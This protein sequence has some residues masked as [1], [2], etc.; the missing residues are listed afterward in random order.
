MKPSVFPAFQVP[1][2]WLQYECNSELMEIMETSYDSAKRYHSELQR[3][4]D[5]LTFNNASA[6]F[7]E[8]LCKNIEF[9]DILE[10]TRVKHEVLKVIEYCY[11]NITSC[12]ALVAIAEAI[13]GKAIQIT[14]FLEEVPMRIEF[15]GVV[16]FYSGYLTTTDGKILT[17]IGGAKLI[18]INIRTMQETEGVLRAFFLQFVPP[19]EHVLFVFK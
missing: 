3:F 8:S 7:A 2:R 13:L 9:F 6:F 18:G 12:G 11:T 14:F 15:N 16:S 10:N 17:T 19:E 5:S 1:E 4:K